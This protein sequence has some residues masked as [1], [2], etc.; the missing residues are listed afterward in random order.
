MHHHRSAAP[1]SVAPRA[2][3]ITRRTMLRGGLGAL[4]LGLLGVGNAVGR[5]LA[6]ADAPTKRIVLVEMNGGW[7]MLLSTDPRDP[8]R[9]YDAIQLGT[10]LLDPAY[11]TPIS[12]TIG[13]GSFARATLLGST[14]RGLTHHLDVLTL[15]RGVNMNTVAHPTGRAYMAT[16][17]SPAGSNAR[18]SSIGSALANAWNTSPTPPLLPFVAMGT[19]AYNHDFP[20]AASALSLDAPADVGDLLTPRR[21]TLSTDAA[22]AHDLEAALVQARTGSCIG[23][24]YTAVD[25]DTGQALPSPVSSEQDVRDRITRVDASAL[26]ARFD[27]SSRADLV[28]LYGSGITRSTSSPALAA[29]TA[30][31]LIKDADAGDPAISAAVSVLLGSGLDTH[32]DWATDQ[33]AGLEPAFDALGAMITDLRATDP[34]LARTLVVVHS[35]FARTGML[36][37]SLGRDHNFASSVMVF[38]GGLATGVFGATGEQDLGIASVDRTT[39]LPSASGVVLTPEDVY[40]TLASALGLDPSVY[41]TTPLPLVPT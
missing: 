41:R 5:S 10:D 37:G 21:S 36:N 23:A 30:A 17:I 16:G 9:S 14:T 34:M 7:D 25:P 15:F 32:R 39:G 26:G 4:G 3:R 18:G 20:E 6:R 33:P 1:G 19:L 27:F 11:Q 12:V 2:F 29:A 8:A 22:L 35:E 13:S 24:G 28:S 38:G 40:A 31:Q